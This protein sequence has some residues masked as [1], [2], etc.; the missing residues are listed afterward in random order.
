MSYAGM[1][2]ALSGLSAIYRC[3]LTVAQDGVA[4]AISLSYSDRFCLDGK[5]LRL[6]S[7]ENLATYG[8]DSTTYQTE[9][10]DFSNVTAHGSVGNGPAYF[11]VQGRNGWLYEYGNGGNSQVLAAGF[12]PATATAWW[13]NKVS[14]AAGNTMI[15]TYQAANQSSNLEGTTVPASISWTPASHGS[16][17]YNYIM[18]FNYQT[19]TSPVR[20]AYIA[21]TPVQNYFLLKNITLQSSGTTVKAYILG[22]LPGASTGRQTL[23]SLTE[24]TDT[25]AGNCLIPSQFVYSA[26]QSGVTTTALTSV[27]GSQFRSGDSAVASF[28]F[29]GDGIND[30]AYYDSGQWWVAFGSPTGYSAPHSTNV[31]SQYA[32]IENIDVSG[33]AAFLLPNSDANWWYYKWNGSSFPGVS[34]GAPNYAYAVGGVTFS[35][36]N[37]DGLADIVSIMG[38]GVIDVQLNTSSSNGIS[39]ATPIQTITTSNTSAITGQV[40][41]GVRKLDYYGDGQGDVIL[42]VPGARF[43]QL[44]V[45]HFTGTTFVSTPLAPLGNGSVLDVGDYNN[46]GCVDTLLPGALYLAACSGQ[47]AVRISFGTLLAIAGMNWDGSGRRAVVVNNGGTLGVYPIVGNTLGALIP[48][49]NIP[50]VSTNVYGPLPDLTGDG[51]E[52]L[53]VFNGASSAAPIQ[54]YPHN[55]LGQ[56]PDL[57]SSVTDGYGNSAAPTYVSIA[58]SDYTNGTVARAGYQNYIGPMYVVNK[59]TFSDP[60]N[61]GGSYYQTYSYA[62]GWIS[63][64]GRGFTGFGTIQKYDSRNALWERFGYTQYFPY[65]QNPAFY[66][67]AFDQANTQLIRFSYDSNEQALTLDGTANNER[68]F[69]YNNTTNQQYQVSWSPSTGSTSGPLIETDTTNFTYDNY[70]NATSTTMTRTDMDSNSPYNGTSWTKTTTVKPYIGDPT[71]QAAALSAW[72]VGLPETIQVQYT[73]GPPGSAAVTRTQ[74]ST[75]NSTDLAAC[76]YTTLVTEP[77]S[78]LYKVTESF[79]YDAFGNI[80]TDTVTGI[81]MTARQTTVNWTSAGSTTGQFP[82]N[83]TDPSGAYTQFNYDFNYGLRSSLTDPNSST[84]SPIV[85]QWQ[86]ADGFGRLTQETRPDGT[87]TTVTYTSC[88]ANNYCPGTSKL[89]VDATDQDA[90][91]NHNYIRDVQFYPDA[92]DRPIQQFSRNHNAGSGGDSFTFT[93]WQYDSLGRR[94]G[95]AI[96][97]LAGGNNTVHPFVTYTYDAL[98]RPTQEQRPISSANSTLQTTGYQYQGRTTTVTDANGHARTLIYDVNGQL[99]ETK[100]ATGY[101]ITLAYDAAGSKTGVTDSLG[102]TLW[103]TAAPAYAYGIAP[104]L[105]NYTDADLGNWSATSYDALGELTGWQDAKGQTFSAIYDALSR[106][107]SRS[108]PDLFTQWTWG[109]STTSHNWGHLAKV[110][111]G[112]GTHPTTCTSSTGYSESETYDSLGRPYQRAIQIPGDTTYTYTLAY[113]ATTGL[114]DT[115]TYPTNSMGY[116]FKVQYGYVNG[117]L[118]SITDTSDP[119]STCGTTCALWTANAVDG[120][121]HFT[122]ETFG[123]GVVVTHNFDTVSGFLNAITA[124]VGGGAALQN[125]SYLFDNVGNLTQ[126]QDNKAGVTE[127]VYP[128]ALNRL[129]YTVGD[130]NTQATYDTMGRLSTWAANGSSNNV[131]DYT[132][133]QSGCT[134]Y[135]NAQP[136]ALRRNTQ[137]TWNTSICYDA[138]GNLAQVGYGQQTLAWTSYTWTSYNQPAQ[139]APDFAPSNYSKFSYDHNHQRWQQIANYSGSLETT[140]YIGGLLEKVVNSSGTAFRYYVPA[141]SNNIV[142]NRWTSGNNPLYYVTKDHLGST[143]LITDRTGSSVVNVKY[144]A[145]GWNENSSTDE[146]TLANITRHG[147]TGQEDLNNVG[148]VNMNGRIYGGGVLPMLFLSP[149]QFIPDPTNTLSYNRYA[150]VNYNPLTDIDP[151]G[152]D[153]LSASDL[154]DLNNN[155]QSTFYFANGLTGMGGTGMIFGLGLSS[156][157]NLQTR[158]FG[159]GNGDTFTQDQQHVT[160]YSPDSQYAVGDFNAQSGKFTWFDGFTPSPGFESD[161]FRNY[162]SF[163]AQV[164]ASALS[165]L[166]EARN[167]AIIIDGGEILGPVIGT[168]ALRGWGALRGVASASESELGI[169]A[170]AKVFCFPKGTEVETPNGQVK[171]EDIKVGDKVMSYDID[172]GKPVVRTVTALIR[173]E[174]V[175][176]YN[177]T[178][179]DETIKVTGA[180]PLWVANESRWVHARDLKPGMELKR[181]DGSLVKIAAVTIE[182]L[183]QPEA[184]FNLEVEHDHNYFAG[185]QRS[186]VLVHNTDPFSIYFSRDPGVIQVTDTFQHGPWA[187]RTLGEAVAEAS[188]LGRLPEGL[189]LNASWV[190]D[191]MV[192]ANNRT[193]WVAQQAGL[194]NV[195]VGGLESNSVAKT[196]MTHLGESGGPFCPP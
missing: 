181:L 175:H 48:L 83:V 22:Y 169:F 56:P 118:A 128:D 66:Q 113:N 107:S 27:A 96:P 138:N 190:N 8:Q 173:K 91:S 194:E 191:T 84:S 45:L 25:S 34:T 20:S 63:L 146:A 94:T 10:A 120:L 36:V 11:T 129:H 148:M 7:S 145:L 80:N 182:K 114:L 105:L 165:T 141:G 54:Y 179:G 163:G 82:M 78:S 132:S 76:R 17:A 61:A 183:A 62:N 50:Y 134:Y 152:F 68:Y 87:Q 92:V 168:L 2:W 185:T 157:P 1:G 188:S 111:T 135:G 86:Y 93:G 47:P 88:A 58:Q 64:Q 89:E 81:G 74:S 59:V 149:D 67:L 167:D 97:V 180:H 30:L 170:E 195:S 103:S 161:I 55:A 139:I 101:A 189:S 13:L 125:N 3:N 136:H 164:R 77:S 102:N 196:V 171:I 99:R 100:D 130:T 150:Y 6:T 143:G 117:L 41:G 122:Q 186:T 98:N 147:Y 5:R 162:A 37:G 109:N 106:M 69:V 23:T 15:V 73:G 39:F 9:L 127:S 184:T 71:Y 172:Q 159:S 12:T 121:G 28:D 142:Y 144:S 44:L 53:A 40:R 174:T 21:G 116:V 151:T 95:V 43:V 124:G 158:T 85:T 104:M 115:L 75:A 155:P 18:T 72:C 123:N 26:G 33:T 90:S 60:S 70:G 35:D 57:L 133:Q 38:N 126:R 19:L 110:C 166:R 178:I 52:A 32:L 46:D 137:G 42:E 108:E 176:W 79:T 31:T 16:T 140:E 187:G 192:A 160:F 4:A 14:D 49:N 29:N 24:C 177:V 154:Y 153:N 131:L 193:L 112:T 65:I 51:S 156:I 119:V